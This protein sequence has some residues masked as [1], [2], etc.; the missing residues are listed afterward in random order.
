MT[1]MLDFILVSQF[2]PEVVQQ[3]Q[4]ILH[5]AVENNSTLIGIEQTAKLVNH[6]KGAHFRVPE[7]KYLLQKVVK[8]IFDY[9]L[10]YK[11]QK[12]A[13][14][15]AHHSN[16][17]SNQVQCENFKCGV[18]IETKSDNFFIYIPLPQQLRQSIKMHYNSIKFYRNREKTDRISDVH[19]G[20]ICKNIDSANPNTTNLTFV[21]NTDGARIFKSTTMSLWPV[22]LYQNFLPPSIRFIPNNILVVALYSGEHKPNMSDFLFPF[23]KELRQLQESGI[24]I[25]SVAKD[26]IFKPFISNCACDLP[27]KA[28][29]Q[30]IMQYNGRSSCGYCLHPGVLVINQK[31]KK[32][33]RYI[34]RNQ[35]EILRTHKQFIITVKKVIERG[36]GCINGIKGLSPLIGLKEFDSVHGFS[37]DYMH[38]IVIGVTAKLYYLW[39]KT[40]NTKQPF[41]LDKNKREILNKRIMSIK[42]PAWISRKPRS[43]DQPLKANEKRSL[44]FFYLRSCL[45]GLL[46]MKYVDHFQLLSAGT[47]ILSEENISL[48]ECEEAS[49]ML[50]QFANKFEGLYGPKNV[51]ANIHLLQHI[52]DE[53]KYSGPLWAQSLFGFEAMNGVLVK[54]VNGPTKV[55]HQITKRYILKQTLACMDTQPMMEKSS[56]IKKHNKILTI[57]TNE[58]EILMS[59]YSVSIGEISHWSAITIKN[60]KYTSL[61]YKQT[62]SIDYVVEFT[63]NLSGKVRYYIESKNVMYALIEIFDIEK[64]IDHL[65]KVRANGKLSLM[66]VS[67]IRE[68]LIYMSIHGREYTSKVPNKYE[69]T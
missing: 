17:K 24:I 47:Y 69:K 62:Q 60:Y 67:E 7:S 61:M 56:T 32:E 27:A 6:V 28:Q 9:E 22:L 4:E 38:C 49:N 51:T 65:K 2:Q 53:V 50:K 40:K 43:L 64:N 39:T 63:N 37:I 48:Q 55:L 18:T 1:N 45:P 66:P 52:G 5:H 29:V 58:E 23:I 20:Y 41:Y 59:S 15:T 19:D 21:M 10:H 54:M 13:T 33:Y 3:V 30:Q 11:C 31:G 12:C 25:E 36:K 42:P 34:K 68:K 16:M 35:P 46:P 44:L 57:P 8:P 14:Y 26:E